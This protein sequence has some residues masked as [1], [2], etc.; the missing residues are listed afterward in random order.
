MEMGRGPQGVAAKRTQS[1]AEESARNVYG[2]VVHLTC[3]KLTAV[4]CK[5][6]GLCMTHL[7]G[8]VGGI[9]STQEGMEQDQGLVQV[10]NKYSLSLLCAGI[11][12][13]AAVTASYHWLVLVQ[14]SSPG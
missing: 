2:T 6:S 8:V 14:A 4:L 1:A 3:L 5:L 13:N 7:R 10:P 12:R 11:L 9:S